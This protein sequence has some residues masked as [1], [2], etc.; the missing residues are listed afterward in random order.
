M[1]MDA[2]CGPKVLMAYQI[3]WDGLK[4][5]S[6]ESDETPHPEGRWTC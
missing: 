5:V 4:S 1:E 6:L 2:V 3:D